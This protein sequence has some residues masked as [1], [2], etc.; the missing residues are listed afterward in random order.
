ML[1]ETIALLLLFSVFV[2]PFGFLREFR[3]RRCPSCH[4]GMRKT[5]L[6]HIIQQG[7]VTTWQCP[8]CGERTFGDMPTLQ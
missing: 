1:W 2:L 6:T 7:E 5:G 8:V 4:R 3:G